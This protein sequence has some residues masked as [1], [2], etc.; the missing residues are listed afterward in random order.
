MNGF[1]AFTKKEFTEQFRSYKSIV[2]VAVLFLFG[3]L[4]P[5]LA[6]IMPEII[7]GMNMQGITINIHKAPDALDAYGQFFKNVGQMGFVVMLLIFSGILA[8]DVTRGTL[9]VLLAKGLSRSAVILSKFM[10]A[11]ILW[12]VGYALSAVTAYGY[13]VYLFG[14]A[15]VPNLLA[16][17][18]GLWLFGVFLIA[19]LILASTLARGSYGG[20]LLAAGLLILLMI[21][22]SFPGV[23]KWNPVT[24]A[25]VN[26]GLIR[27]QF[28]AGDMVVPLCVTLA[29]IALCLVLSILI[30]RKKRL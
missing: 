7:S 3:M 19:L 6:K 8:Q 23:S 28:A 1:T 4:S 26:D 13:T 2:L 14:G 11:L 17:L 16:A 25:A 15:M 27:N 22:N 20:L 10:S 21:I 18:A 5:L 9:I 12:T 29:L 24:L 30:F